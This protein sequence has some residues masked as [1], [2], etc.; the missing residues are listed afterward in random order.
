MFM[1]GYYEKN[2][3]VYVGGGVSFVLF[4]FGFANILGSEVASLDVQDVGTI[5]LN[6][7]P[8]SI[9]NHYQNRVI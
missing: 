8:I 7:H 9:Q 6:P 3:D 4:I 1:L 2:I 5:A